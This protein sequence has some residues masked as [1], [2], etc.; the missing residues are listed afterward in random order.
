MP[1]TTIVLFEQT[2]AL[3]SLVSTASAG[4]SA[5]IREVRSVAAFQEAVQSGPFPIAVIEN[6]ASLQETLELLDAVR[7]ARGTCVVVGNFPDWPTIAELLERGATITLARGHDARRWR[8]L[9]KRLVEQS[10]RR[11][12]SAN[13]EPAAT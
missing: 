2:A 7:R 13:G 10:Q 8:P 4:L 11:I 12:R 3:A 6:E 9:L 5:R 1:A